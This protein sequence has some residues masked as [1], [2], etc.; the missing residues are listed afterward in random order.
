MMIV[1][2]SKGCN[3]KIEIRKLIPK[4][5]GIEELIERNPSKI[6]DPKIPYDL[7][8]LPRARYGDDQSLMIYLAISNFWRSRWR[9]DE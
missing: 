7:L 5:V 1:L 3:G 9:I 6:L 4:K 2:S 8:N